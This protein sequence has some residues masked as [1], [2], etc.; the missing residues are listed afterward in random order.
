MNTDRPEHIQTR[1]HTD[2]NADRQEHRQTRTQTDYW[3]NW[4][5]TELHTSKGQR[6]T[7][8]KTDR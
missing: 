4:K 2:K 7:E 1:T 5:E 3:R 8:E 6:Q